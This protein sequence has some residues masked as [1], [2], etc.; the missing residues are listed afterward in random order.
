MR[1]SS[2]GPDQWVLAC[3]VFTRRYRTDYLLPLIF[4]CYPYGFFQGNKETLRFT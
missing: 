3:P 1:I 2:D 4:H